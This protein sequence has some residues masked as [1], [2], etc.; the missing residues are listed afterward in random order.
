MPATSATLLH[1][2]FIA[3]W[4]LAT[5]APML[6]LLAVAAV[7]DCRTRTIPNWRAGYMRPCSTRSRWCTSGS[8]ARS[9]PTNTTGIVPRPS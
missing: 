3:P 8:S 2:W 4:F 7:I 1:E 9:R 5:L 6:I